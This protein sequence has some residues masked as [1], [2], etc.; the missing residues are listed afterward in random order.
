MFFCSFYK[1]ITAGKVIHAD[2]VVK[3]S[4]TKKKA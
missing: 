3:V 4:T 1:K 2:I